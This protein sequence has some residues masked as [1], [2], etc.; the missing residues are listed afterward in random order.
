AQLNAFIHVE[1]LAGHRRERYRDDFDGI[2]KRR[3][4]RVAT[5]NNAA[6]YWIY[7]GRE[8]GFEYELCRSF[9]EKYGLRLEMLVAPDRGALLDWVDSGKAD[10][11]AATLTAT[12]K[13]KQR[14]SFSA[15]YLFPVEVVVSGR[16]QEGNPLVADT[17]DLATVP[18]HVRKSSSYY[19]TLTSLAASRGDTFDIRLVP[20]DIETEEIL[21]RV[22]EGKY[23]ATVC[24]DY[25]AHMEE[26]YTD[27]IA[28]GP[29]LTEPRNVGWAVRSDASRLKAAVDSFFTDGP[30]KP[31]RLKY[32]ILYRRYFKSKRRAAMARSEMRADV[33][34]KLSSYDRLMKTY[35]KKRGFDWRMIAAQTY[36]ESKFNPKA[37]SWAGAQGLMQLMP[38]TA[39]ELGVADPFDP[40]QN[41]RGGTTYMIRMMNRFDP[42][43]AYRDRYHFA[44]ASY[45]A[46]YGHVED[47]RRL[48]GQMGWNP[49]VWFD[50]V[51]EAML[52]LSKREYARKARYGYVRGS[53]P[54]IYVS[55]IQRLYNHYSQI[56]D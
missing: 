3:T 48:A 46:G 19:G 17:A 45:N 13:R 23:V 18:I 34:G 12:E 52:L 16:D 39:Q 15:P 38:A 29:P 31:K 6:T 32:N 55:N 36:Q 1:S 51:E 28:V 7:R 24:D 49:N 27:A 30:Y 11:A 33:H 37:R 42:S 35:A 2:L 26:R 54:V 9:A 5:R 43:I 8:V 44:L 21:R 22:A 50:N 20:E 40:R 53:E 4:L 25:L 56:G 10:I 14:V 41:L 47:A